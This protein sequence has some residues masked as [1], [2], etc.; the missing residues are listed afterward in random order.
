MTTCC[1]IF[2][3]GTILIPT[4][5]VSPSSYASYNSVQWGGGGVFVKLFTWENI[6]IL[7]IICLFIWIILLLYHTTRYIY[8]FKINIPCHLKIRDTPVY[9][10]GGLSTWNSEGWVVGTFL[11]AYCFSFSLPCPG[12]TTFWLNTGWGDLFWFLVLLNPTVDLVIRRKI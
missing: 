8:Y 4:F 1:S 5:C 12:T 11:I 6:Y 2:S 7:I 10:V 3:G 9:P